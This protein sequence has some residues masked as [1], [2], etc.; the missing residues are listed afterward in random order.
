MMVKKL[1]RGLALAL[2]VCLLAALCAACGGS[3]GEASATES[4]EPAAETESESEPAAESE[5]SG[6]GGTEIL[7]GF[8]TPPGSTL[9]GTKE[10]TKMV[11]Q[12]YKTSA[13]P[14]EVVSFYRE[15]LSSAGWTIE[16]GDPG[17]AEYGVS[18]KLEGDYFDV[19]ADKETSGTTHFELCAG[20]GTE[21][22]CEALSNEAKDSSNSRCACR[23]DVRRRVL[24]GVF[25]RFGVDVRYVPP[26]VRAYAFPA[27]SEYM[28][29]TDGPPA[30]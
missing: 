9:Q 11:H 16:N 6:E 10:G 15:Q 22:E 13:A 26:P 2:G 17:S 25:A 3:S 14:Q 12:D 24:G 1:G 21:P 5:A 30:G 18:A 29:G 28:S 8:S 20:P 27:C 19:E 7:A 4:S 23:G